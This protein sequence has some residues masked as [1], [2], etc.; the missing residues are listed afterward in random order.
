MVLI[1][2]VLDRRIKPNDMCLI[3]SIDEAQLYTLKASNLWIY[4]WI[5]LDCAPGQQYKKKFVLPS[6][7]I[8]GSNKPQILD[9]FIYPR[10]YYVAAVTTEG[11]KIWDTAQD[12]IHISNLFLIFIMA[13]TPSMSQLD[14]QVG[15][16]GGSGCC[17]YCSLKRHY[18]PN[19]S[20]YYP[21]L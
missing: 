17:L 10:L 11:L 3:F 13:D 15:H 18:K 4:I 8:H 19:Q 7:F 9:S 5:I 12:Y 14:G 2:I 6:R 20:Y 1:T 16:G 21:V